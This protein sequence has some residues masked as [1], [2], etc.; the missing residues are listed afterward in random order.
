MKRLFVL[1]CTALALM[2]LAA[3]LTAAPAKLKVLIVDG[4]NNHQWA[5]TTPLLQRIL[6]DT[7]RFTVD[8][9]TTPPGKAWFKRQPAS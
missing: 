8:I 4:Q 5:T 1:L 6:E 2:L 7:G 9:S 3:S